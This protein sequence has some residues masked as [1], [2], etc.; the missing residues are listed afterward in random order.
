MRP[1]RL[2]ATAPILEIVAAGNTGCCGICGEHSSERPSRDCPD[3]G[4]TVHRECGIYA[5]ACGTYACA[6]MS[7]SP[8]A[9]SGW[10]S[11]AGRTTEPAEGGLGRVRRF[12]LPRPRWMNG[13]MEDLPDRPRPPREPSA[14]LPAAYPRGRSLLDTS[15][16]YRMFG[17]GVELAGYCLWIALEVLFALGS[18][19]F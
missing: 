3:C 15:D 8:A 4:V 7:R 5:Q 10:M 14:P 16:G 17:A 9:R 11:P 19:A 2:N 12:T 6:G 1:A 13:P 18:L